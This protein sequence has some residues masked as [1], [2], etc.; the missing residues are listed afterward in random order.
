MKKTRGA[1]CIRVKTWAAFDIRSD[2]RF[3]ARHTGLRAVQ[4]PD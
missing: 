4:Y 1:R 3:R 2:I